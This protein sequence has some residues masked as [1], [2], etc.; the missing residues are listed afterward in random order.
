MRAVSVIG[1][2]VMMAGG[3]AARSPT[4]QAG[5]QRR[6]EEL[7]QQGAALQ[8]QLEE[9]QN[10]LFLLEDKVDTNK[11][12]MERGRPVRLPVIRLRPGAADQDAEE[13]GVPAQPPT[14]G[15]GRGEDASASAVDDAGE[16]QPVGGRSMVAR[17]PVL[18]QG[19]ARRHGPRPLLRLHGSG[20][21]P[22]EAAPAA[23]LPEPAGVKEKLP[24]IPM[25]KVT[26]ATAARA[27]GRSMHD[28]QEALAKYRA[29]SFQA[30]A[31][32]FR[33][34][35]HRY[36]QHAYADNA[37]YW[38]GECWY[39]LRNYRGALKFFRQVVEQYPT[40]NK[41]PDAMLK[42]AFCYVRMKDKRNARAVLGQ[43]MENYPHSRVAKLASEAMAKLEGPT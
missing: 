18:Y 24:V 9:M 15:D 43:V 33:E 4:D 25:P 5:Q 37:L 20:A 42:M 22:S 39:D 34:F 13:A 1:L 3:C 28:Y 10:R 21:L 26:A 7:A 17:P 41:A 38:Q 12:A 14:A 8:Q 27:D 31:E 23:L 2:V 35:F 40:G 32:A 6:V 19:E 30:A 36:N 11:V 16:P 29:G